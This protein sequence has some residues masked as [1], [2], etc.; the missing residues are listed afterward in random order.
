MNSFNSRVSYCRS[1]EEDGAITDRNSALDVLATE[2]SSEGRI[3]C[4]DA[5]M[6]QVC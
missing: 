5:N 6:E 3:K 4:E 2:G 1:I